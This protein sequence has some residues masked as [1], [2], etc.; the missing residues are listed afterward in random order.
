MSDSDVTVS[1]RYLGPL[2]DVIQTEVV[3]ARFRIANFLSFEAGQT[4]G[5]DVGTTVRAVRSAAGALVPALPVLLLSI[6]LPSR[7]LLSR[8]LLTGAILTRT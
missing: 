8:V 3:I 4:D 7:V 2:Q 6:L 1:D 5:T